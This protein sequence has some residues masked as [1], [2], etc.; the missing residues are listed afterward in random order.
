MSKPSSTKSLVLL[1][2]NVWISEQMLTSAVGE[3]FL[4]ALA[5]SGGLIA[6]PEVVEMEVNQAWGNRAAES[7]AQMHKHST[8]LYQISRQKFPLLLPNESEISKGIQERWQELETTIRRFSINEAQLKSALKRVVEGRLPSGSN[9]EQ[10]RDC[11]IWETFLELNRQYETH[12]ISND[13]IFYQERNRSRG[14]AR[15]LEEEIHSSGNAAGLYPKLDNYLEA[16]G[17]SSRI[18]YS[19]KIGGKLIE[20]ILALMQ[21]EIPR[22]ERRPSEITLTSVRGFTTLQ[23]SKVAVSFQVRGWMSRTESPTERDRAIFFAEG[24]A[25][26]DILTDVV[27]E[28]RL[29]SHGWRLV[30]PYEPD[31]LAQ[32]WAESPPRSRYW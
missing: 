16:R 18:D 14:L 23:H 13:S 3:A 10:F 22:Q 4:F 9:N 26:Y 8:E 20:A 7:L 12:L 1:D 11:C 17:H 29:R 19:K 28:V 21:N 5:E 32:L 30:Y 31:D 27:S 15:L 25:A 24:T 2:A 6:I